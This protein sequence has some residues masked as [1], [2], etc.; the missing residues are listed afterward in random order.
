M[1]RFCNFKIAKG[2]RLLADRWTYDKEKQQGRMERRQD[3]T[4]QAIF[5][6]YDECYL[7]PGVTLKDILLLV[8]NMN[9]CK[10]LSPVLTGGPWLKEMIAE[11]LDQPSKPTEL[12]FI[13]VRWLPTIQDDLEHGSD[14]PLFFTDIE[15]YGEK[16]DSVETYALDLS[17]LN[18]LVNCSI[19]V[20]CEFN[21][22]DIRG[23]SETEMMR[24]CKDF[25]LFH[26]LKGIFW[27]LS[28][29]GSP[30]DRASRLEEILRRVNNEEQSISWEQ[31]KIN[32]QEK[33]DE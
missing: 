13:R 31:M 2:G 21:I 17:P 30:I 3:I 1:P 9:N 20:E 8:R 24:I 11:G 28:F 6:L 15:I 4:D 32:L 7:E 19:S 10:L 12:K 16:E 23:E 26:I 14:R 33:L 25:T 29:H 5:H 27:N 22:T 18:A